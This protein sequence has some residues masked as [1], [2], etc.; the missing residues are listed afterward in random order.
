MRAHEPILAA[1]H[2]EG[3]CSDLREPLLDP[4]GKRRTERRQERR[5]SHSRRVAGSHGDQR[6]RLASGV[7]QPAQQL[8]AGTSLLR[9]D[10]RADQHQRPD[11]VRS[12]HRELGH[13]LAAERVRN[14]RGA[15]ELESVEAGAERVSEPSDSQWDARSLAA[16]EAG[17][18]GREDRETPG[19]GFRER[20]HVAAGDA[21]AV[22]QHHGLAL[23]HEPGVDAEAADE[24]PTA[25]DRWNAPHL[26]SLHAV[27]VRSITPIGR[28]LGYAASRRP[29]SPSR[30]RSR[31]TRSWIGGCVMNNVAT[32]TRGS[33]LTA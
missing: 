14:E 8:P 21:E 28:S 32:P 29:G 7:A 30:A 2:D 33:G 18:L 6:Q 23:T 31:R 9:I 1:A 5:E 12:P 16:A 24:E 19:Q 15:L 20:K 22:D 11:P 13:H 4:V 27:G 26:G 3:R 17:Q 25:G 10:G